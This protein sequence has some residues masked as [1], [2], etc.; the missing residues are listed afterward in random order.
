[1]FK[2]VNIGI[3]N[4]RQILSF[5]QD[6]ESET[7]CF[8]NVLIINTQSVILFAISHFMKEMVVPLRYIDCK[9]R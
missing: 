8:V 7:L 5:K 2:M 1:M 6:T 3:L 4:I 9:Q